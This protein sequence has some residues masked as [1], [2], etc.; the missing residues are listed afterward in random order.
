MYRQIEALCYTS[1]DQKE[2]INNSYAKEFQ[3]SSQRKQL[4]NI[5]QQCKI[6]QILGAEVAC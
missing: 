5:Y 2:T 4:G 1:F 6:L 3:K